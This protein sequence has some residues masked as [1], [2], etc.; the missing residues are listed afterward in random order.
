MSAS[1]VR[2]GQ[3]YVEI[4]ANPNKFLAAL[5]AINAR[6]GDMGDTLRSAGIGM[7]AIGAAIS[8]PIMAVGGAFVE[9]TGEIQAMRRALADIGKAVGEAVAPAFVGM[10]NVIAGA[11]RAVSRFI[12]ANQPLI[13][14]ALAIGGYFLAWGMATTA[15]GVAMSSF[16]RIVAGSIGPITAFAGAVAS[17]VSAFAAFAVSGPVLAAVGTLAALAAG[18][19]AAGANVRGLGRAI[20]GAFANPIRD[21]M[22]LFNDLAGTASLTIEGI[23]RAISAGDLRGAVDVLFAGW[24]AS[25]ARGTQALLNATDPVAEEVQNVFSDLGVSLAAWWDQTW[26]DIATS[27]WGV[28]LLGAVDNVTNGVMAYWDSLTGSLQKAWISYSAW[29][30][31][32]T[33]T[34]SGLLLGVF[35]NV[36]AG[37]ATKWDSFTGELRKAWLTFSAWSESAADGWANLF[38]SIFD[39]IKNGVVGKWDEMIGGLQKAWARYSAWWTGD[40]AKMRQEFERIDAEN[41]RRAEDRQQKPAP[42][43]QDD[44]PQGQ[45][46]KEAERRRKLAAE[47]A[48]IDAENARRAE[49]RGKSTKGVVGRSGLSDDRKREVARD[50]AAADEANVNRAAERERIRPG[51]AGRTGLTD[52]QKERMRQETRD[53]QAAMFEEGERLRRERTERTARNVRDRAA[54]VDQA[55]AN[56]RAQVDRFPVPPPVVV[57]QEMRTETAGTFSAFGLGQL[58]TGSIDKQQLEEL[59]RIRQELQRAA[60]AGGIGP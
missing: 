21:A 10:A 24:Q 14:T 39:K 27:G 22:T 55:N 45:D 8:G 35:D 54:A 41:A 20:G 59:K 25:W 38:T 6:I 13:R 56:L 3:V 43:G 26:T 12:R 1:A 29:S 33:S 16:S 5:R 18:M 4:G 52:E 60:M 19:A 44:K 48:A 37:A 49:E 34:W 50:L 58:G 2:G 15:L 23:Y 40:T 42:Q 11:A 17:S 32:A 36:K 51:F 46:D 28:V 57:P 9:Q 7:S 30:E 31:S 47:L 53:R